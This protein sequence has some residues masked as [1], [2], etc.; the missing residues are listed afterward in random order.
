MFQDG[1]SSSVGKGIVMRLAALRW[2]DLCA[3]STD[4][5]PLVID[6]H[7]NTDEGICST[8]RDL[9]QATIPLHAKELSV[10]SHGNTTPAKVGAGGSIIIEVLPRLLPSFHDRDF[11][12]KSSVYR[13]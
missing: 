9:S 12:P 4:L 5:L 10:R 13:C 2:W 6:Q 7:I 3:S 1:N 11:P 8:Y